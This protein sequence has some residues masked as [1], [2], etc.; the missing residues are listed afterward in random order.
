[1]SHDYQHSSSPM[2]CYDTD[3]GASD[4]TMDGHAGACCALRLLSVSSETRITTEEC[5]D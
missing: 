2:S 1:M 4:T 3:M 5:D